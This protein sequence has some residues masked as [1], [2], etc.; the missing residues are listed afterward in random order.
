MGALFSNFLA[1]TVSDNPLTNVATTLNSAALVNMPVIAAPDY[2]WIVFDPMGIAGAPE[3]A[4]VTAHTAS[5]TSVTIARA[6]QGSAARQHLLGV[7]WVNTGTAYDFA[8]PAENPRTGTR[9]FDDLFSVPPA[10]GNS[11]GL[12]QSGTGG[13][14]AL[15]A[16]DWPGRAGI[17]SV[18]TQASATGQAVIRLEP[19]AVL[20]GGG[21]HTFETSVQVP[22]LSTGTE[23]FGVA[24]GFSDANSLTPTDGAAF[25]YDEG[26]VA[27]GTAA[28]Y[29]QT[30]TAANGVRTYNTGLTQV[31][32]TAGQW[33]RL[34]VEVNAAATA[35]A[36]YV[37]GVLIATHVANI[38]SGAG[39]QTG[40][41]TGI[42]KSIGVTARLAYVDYVE[43]TAEFTVAR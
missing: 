37:D 11:T 10:A 28:A 35:A 8:E 33:Y 40:L 30:S 42:V 26:G 41:A 5:A 4:K 38:P 17:I 9:F 32:V 19:T 34:R 21:A 15:V 29:W 6:Q 31:T 1:G 20:F 24:A 18:S 25:L 43:Y 27:T 7:P 3:I 13:T 36:F 14:W 2:M 22:V 12:Y 16:N 39:R 23:R